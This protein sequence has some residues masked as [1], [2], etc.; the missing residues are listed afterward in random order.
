MACPKEKTEAFDRKLEE[1]TEK[2]LQEIRE[3][4]SA[5][6]EEQ[7]QKLREE[8]DLRLQQMQESFAKKHTLIA[9]GLAARILEA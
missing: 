3:S 9:E 7:L 6:R 2:H 1:E 8:T 5:Q 4:F